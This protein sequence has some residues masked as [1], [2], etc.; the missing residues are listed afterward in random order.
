MLIRI[1]LLLLIL[2]TGACGYKSDLYLKPEA[3]TVPDQADTR[4]EETDK[5]RNDEPDR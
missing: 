4:E 2:A 3:V 5:H 1:T